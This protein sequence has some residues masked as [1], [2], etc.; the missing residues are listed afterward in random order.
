MANS[1][2]TLRDKILTPIR[3]RRV[4]LTADD[5]LVGPPQLIEPVEDFDASTGTSA[6]PYGV[7][8]GVIATST[9]TGSFTL[10]A[11]PYPGLIKK[12]VLS[13]TSTGGHQF[14][15]TNATIYTSSAGT[16]SAVVNL[17]SPGAAVILQAMTTAIW[18]VI[19]GSFGTTTNP[20]VTYTTST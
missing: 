3:R 11:P 18:R 10:Q 2:K 6:L 15:A 16:S 13:S 19:G 17:Y 4:G 5:Y 14:T 20:L 1:L 9:A 7:T 8:R 12:L